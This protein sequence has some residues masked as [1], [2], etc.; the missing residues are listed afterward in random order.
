MCGYD[1]FYWYE[2]ELDTAYAME[3]AVFDNLNDYY[4]YLEDLKNDTQT[5]DYESLK[6]F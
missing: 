1:P 5:Q 6:G 2:R 4:D 3:Q